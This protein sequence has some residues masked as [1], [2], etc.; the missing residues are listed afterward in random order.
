MP[1][2][3]EVT[4]QT[5][6]GEGVNTAVVEGAATQAAA[7]AKTEASR[8]FTQAELDEI[9]KTRLPEDRKRS[10]NKTEKTVSEKLA[11]KE[12]ELDILV[13][14]RVNAKMTERD[15]NDKRTA[16]Q[17]EYGLTDEQAKRLTG[18]TPDELAADAET[19]FGQLKTRKAP[20]IR[21]GT[22][23]QSGA[24]PNVADMTGKEVVANWD[25]LWRAANPK[26]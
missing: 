1:D 5:S 21:T 25:A 18:T 7:Q 17:A 20:I 23:G 26:A 22:Q 6:A 8:T 2:L 15:L 10:E 24:L 3:T 19:L 16:I 14:Q 9:V 13:E 4:V 11:E 12:K